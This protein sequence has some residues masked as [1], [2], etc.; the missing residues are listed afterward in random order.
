VSEYKDGRG[1]YYLA[2]RTADPGGLREDAA[3]RLRAWAGCVQR[4]IAVAPTKAVKAETGVSGG[5]STPPDRAAIRKEAH[6]TVERWLARDL[7]ALTPEATA[8]ETTDA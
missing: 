3:H 8:P 6:A 2:S 5:S 1:D 4:L 7:A